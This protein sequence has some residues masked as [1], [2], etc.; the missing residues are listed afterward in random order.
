MM[1]FFV[2]SLTN[3]NDA[4]V[5]LA[6]RKIFSQEGVKHLKIIICY[7]HVLLAV[8][9]YL[10]IYKYLQQRDITLLIYLHLKLQE[11]ICDIPS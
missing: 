6:N 9:F 10:L 4:R 11:K 3:M 7:S 2:D 1:V 8:Y 5:F